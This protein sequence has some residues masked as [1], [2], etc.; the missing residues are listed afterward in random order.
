M[1]LAR[2]VVDAVILEGR[3]YREVARAHGVS[4]S[5]VGKLVVRFREGG[6][7]AI[8]PRS[9]APKRIP[10][11]TPEDLEDEIVGLRKE[12]ADQGLDAGAQTIHYHLGRVHEQVPSVTTIWR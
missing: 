8:A 2:Y 1:D 4:K 7:E 10:H 12:L 5:Y 9:R 11:R 6:Y 3:S